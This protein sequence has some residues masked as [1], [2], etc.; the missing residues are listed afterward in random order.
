MRIGTI[1]LAL[2]L[3]IAAATAS[4]ASIHVTIGDDPVFAQTTSP[5]LSSATEAAGHI[6]IARSGK[7]ADD[8]HGDD[9]GRHHGG[10]GK[11]GKG[12]GGHDDGP[13]HT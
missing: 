1:G 7:G 2:G 3:V 6:V 5:T 10:K 9:H 13:N 4:Q 11:G 8:P 12:H